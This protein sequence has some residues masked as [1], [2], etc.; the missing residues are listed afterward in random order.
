MS[1]SFI[2]VLP[3]NKKLIVFQCKLYWTKID[4]TGLTDDPAVF[5]S[6]DGISAADL[7]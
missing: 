7:P 3:C 2:Q 1:F 5:L 6:I 4:L